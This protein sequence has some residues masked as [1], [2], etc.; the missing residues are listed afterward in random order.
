MGK[1]FGVIAR[2]S[3]IMTSPASVRLPWAHLDIIALP[4]HQT[5]LADFEAERLVRH[6]NVWMRM[7]KDAYA[8]PSAR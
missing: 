5:T 4:M 3:P 1:P 2:G 7:L 6:S 8:R